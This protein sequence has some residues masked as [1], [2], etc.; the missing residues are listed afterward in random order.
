MAHVLPAQ[1]MDGVRLHQSETLHRNI[2]CK[3]RGISGK[4][5]VTFS[6][7]LVRTCN[8]HLDHPI[9]PC[10]FE[11]GLLLWRTEHGA[12]SV[13]VNVLKCKRSRD[14][15]LSIK[16][17]NFGALLTQTYTH[18]IRTYPE[19]ASS[20]KQS[21]SC[22]SLTSLKLFVI[23]PLLCANKRLIFPLPKVRH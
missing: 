6:S 11:H 16:S 15:V 5:L 14:K 22:Q 23:I 19:Q 2:P 1:H 13:T 20:L 10:L 17:L 9:G 4:I 18:I 12:M 7:A 21:V 8:W 3:D